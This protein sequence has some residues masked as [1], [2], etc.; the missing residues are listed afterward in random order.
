MVS[1]TN[2]LRCV[3][4]SFPVDDFL[5]CQRKHVHNENYDLCGTVIINNDDTIVL[6]QSFLKKTTCAP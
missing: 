1:K 4:L 5:H 2:R 3:L 6:G